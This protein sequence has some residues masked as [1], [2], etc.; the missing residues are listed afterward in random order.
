MI[1]RT[2]YFGNQA[3]LGM[4]NSQLEICLLAVENNIMSYLKLLKEKV[5]QRAPLKILG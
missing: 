3:Y 1:K 2:L 4:K 5:S